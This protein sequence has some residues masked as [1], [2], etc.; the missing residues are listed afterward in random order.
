MRERYLSKTPFLTIVYISKCNINL[1]G[2]FGN[3]KKKVF[4]NR[5]SVHI[6]WKNTKSTEKGFRPKQRIKSAFCQGKSS[7]SP[8][9]GRSWGQTVDTRSNSGAPLKTLGFNGSN[10]PTTYCCIV[11][12]YSRKLNFF[13]L[14]IRLCKIFDN[15][16][17][18]FWFSTLFS[19]HDELA[20]GGNFWRK[21]LN[22][23]FAANDLLKNKW[24]KT[25]LKLL[26]RK[27]A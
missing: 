23:S 9:L 22:I 15:F 17:F 25:R 12:K 7:T 21:I 8:H 1:P 4:V 20:R 6:S 10:I 2:F 14:K 26:K 11:S 16:H 13:G 18:Y 5:S 3:S 24:G 27:A 19:I